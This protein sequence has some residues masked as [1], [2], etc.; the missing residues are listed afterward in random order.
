MISQSN[1]KPKFLDQYKELHLV[2]GIC[3]KTALDNLAPF[4]EQGTHI[5]VPPSLPPPAKSVRPTHTLALL[6]AKSHHA[7][8][9]TREHRHVLA[10]QLPASAAHSPP[11]IHRQ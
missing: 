3:A 7:A 2:A 8:A 1:Y 9:A 4:F 10:A 5:F 6:I 11:L